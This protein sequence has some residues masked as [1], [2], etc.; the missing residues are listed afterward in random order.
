MPPKVADVAKD[1]E[2]EDRE[3]GSGGAPPG[4]VEIEVGGDDEE[5]EDDDSGST[6]AEGEPGERRRK[7]QERGRYKQMYEE[8][9]AARERDRAER[10]RENRE[11]SERIG[12]LEQSRQPA[13]QEQAEPEVA[14]LKDVRDQID[15]LTDLWHRLPPEQQKSQRQQFLEKMRGLQQREG[16]L[17]FDLREKRRAKA[18][19]PSPELQQRQAEYDYIKS[20]YPDVVTNPAAWAF[21]QNAYGM[22]RALGKPHHVDTLAQVMKETRRQFKLG[23]YS[24]EDPS[25]RR[26]LAGVPASGGSGGSRPRR[27]VVLDPILQKMANAKYKHIPD[28]KKRFELFAKNEMAEDDERH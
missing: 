14:Q 2:K 24:G 27:K 12:R 11:W 5:D 19:A 6:Q 1:I 13:Q 15:M 9:R 8:E 3:E 4:A 18:N 21:A 20:N 7:K 28:E 22:Q 23:G 16:D 10:E 25:M 17:D 26:K